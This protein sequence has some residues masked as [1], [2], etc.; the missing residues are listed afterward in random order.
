MMKTQWLVWVMLSALS[1]GVAADEYTCPPSL[2]VR[3]KLVSEPEGWAGM[4]ENAAGEMAYV[5]TNEVTDALGLVEVTLYAGEPK[6][7]VVL[8][9]DNA[10][11]L[12]EQEGDSIWSFGTAAEQTAQP[13]YIACHYAGSSMSVFRKITAPVKSCTWYFKPEAVNNSVSCIPL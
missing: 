12:S 3:A 1:V 7:Q 11:S 10:D 13:L 2:E 9:P 8:A 6:Q 4:Y 5:G